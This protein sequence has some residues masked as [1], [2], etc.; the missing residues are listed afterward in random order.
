ML[1]IRKLDNYNFTLAKKKKEPRI[2]SFN[3]RD[4]VYEWD[5]S[6][7]YYGTILEAI[8][9]YIKHNK[10]DGYTRENIPIQ[11]GKIKPSSP[12]LMMERYLEVKL[13]LEDL[14]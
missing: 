10:I 5:N 1:L 9:G 4:I 6:P 8:V 13:D 2:V 12:L 7:L 14:H 11:L 3:G